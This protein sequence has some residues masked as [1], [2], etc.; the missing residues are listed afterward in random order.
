MGPGS[1][2]EKHHSVNLPCRHGEILVLTLCEMQYADKGKNY[3][4]LMLK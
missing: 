2:F 1:V 3:E 4:T